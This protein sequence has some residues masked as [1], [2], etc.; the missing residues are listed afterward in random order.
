MAVNLIDAL[1]KA[2]S[3]GINSCAVGM[4]DDMLNM[5]SAPGYINN[6]SYKGKVLVDIATY[7]YNPFKD[8]SVISALHESAL[9]YVLFLILFVLIGGAYVQISRTCPA[10][11][12]LGAKFKQGLTLSEYLIIC[13]ALIVLGPLVPFSMY[14][15]LIFSY[16]TSQLTMVG[17]L[18]SILFTPDNVT[19]YVFM[20][21]L[22]MIMSGLYIWRTL[23]IG[24]SI[25][26]CLFILILL[27]IPYT[28]KL[29][30]QLYLYFILMALMQPI[31]LGFTCAG[32]GIIQTIAPHI[33]MWQN[34]CNSI[35]TL[36]LLGV[37]IM[38]IFGPWTILKLLG[39]SKQVVKMVI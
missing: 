2:V 39:R 12:L 26:Y 18:P 24:L 9:L 36:F 28:R 35:L 5:S 21:F 25:G 8:V 14:C 34:F 3:D 30:I 20:C 17:I 33:G 7:T 31:I 10:R 4:G 15:V 13:F 19:L 11:E 27:A 32:V 1:T 22:Y 23:V 6:G 37:G 29:G 16:A 38:F